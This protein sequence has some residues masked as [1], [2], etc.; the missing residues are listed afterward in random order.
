MGRSSLFLLSEI[1]AVPDQLR[2][3]VSKCVIT[4][5]LVEV[6]F[7][8]DRFDILL[9]GLGYLLNYYGFAFADGLIHLALVSQCIV[10]SQCAGCFFDSS[11][12]D[13]CFARSIFVLPFVCL[14]ESESLFYYWGRGGIEGRWKKQMGGKLPAL[15]CLPANLT[16]RN[17]GLEMSGGIHQE[18]SKLSRCR[19]KCEHSEVKAANRP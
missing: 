16:D 15:F 5:S 17:A 14:F 1:V 18:R 3:I 7:V 8:D 4:Y 2:T 19:C 11:L 12:D 9:H 6:A 13:I 10:S